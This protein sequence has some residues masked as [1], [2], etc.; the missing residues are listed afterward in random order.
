MKLEGPFWLSLA[1]KLDKEAT[2][3]ATVATLKPRGL[4]IGIGRA[5]LFIDTPSPGKVTE[6]ECAVNERLFTALSRVWYLSPPVFPTIVK[7]KIWITHEI[8][9]V[10]VQ[11]SD[12]ELPPGD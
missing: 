9:I 4:T 8:L 10:A 11:N 7:G 3:Y 6:T 2:Y 1:L 12:W 5:E